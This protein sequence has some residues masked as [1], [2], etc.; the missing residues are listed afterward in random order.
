MRHRR[1][2]TIWAVGL[3]VAAASTCAAEA[4]SINDAAASAAARIPLVQAVAAAERHAN[5]NAT[6]AE[7]R[8]TSNGWICEVEVVDGSRVF[9][10]RIDA[11]NGGVISSVED[12]IDDDDRGRERQPA[13]GSIESPP[14]RPSAPAS[15]RTN[16]PREA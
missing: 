4:R 10:V 6:R 7:Y 14:R 2:T 11:G 12:R 8:F 16:P 13:A 5:G 9:D 1:E 15:A 3:A